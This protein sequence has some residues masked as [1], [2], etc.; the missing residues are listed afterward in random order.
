MKVDFLGLTLKVKFVK[1]FVASETLRRP[2]FCCVSA[3]SNWLTRPIVSRELQTHD[4]KFVLV[5]ICLEMN[6]PPDWII[7][8]F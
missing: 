5:R 8:T 7:L 1:K 6:G 2:T 3:C 4:W